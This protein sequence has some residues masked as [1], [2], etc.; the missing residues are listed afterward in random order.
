MK[1]VIDAKGKVPGRVATE[2]AI[3]L[4]GKNRTDFSRNKIPDVEVEVTGASEMNLSAKKLKEKMY[5]RPSLY[6]GGLKIESQ[7]QVVAKKGA[8]EVLRR[9]IYGML[10]KNKLRPRMMKNLKIN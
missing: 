2:V 3:F 6:P 5:Y 10:P 4:M 9:A 1:H 8:Q 7:E